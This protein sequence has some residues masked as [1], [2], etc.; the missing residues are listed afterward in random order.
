MGFFKD[1]SKYKPL[2]DERDEQIDS[3]SKN[4]S[5]A[6]VT[7]GIQILAIMCLVKGN[8]AWKGCIGALSIGCS[9]ELLYKYLAYKEKPYLWV[10]LITLLM[11]IAFLIW[12]GI[13]G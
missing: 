10:G 2:K 12:F 9:V 7:T 6:F 3:D 5:W 4:V 8:P 1:F 11:G 13:S